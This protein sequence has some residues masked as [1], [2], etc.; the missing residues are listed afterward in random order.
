MT[1]RHVQSVIDVPRQE[2][3]PSVPLAVL[4]PVQIGKYFQITPTGLL[5]TGEPDFDTC[6]G[7][8]EML[9]TFEVGLQF[10]IG[11]YAR[12]VEGRF[13]EQASQILDATGW[14]EATLRVYTW[15]SGKVPAE[16]R[17]VDRGLSFKH[18]MAVAGL[19]PSQQ[20]K[21]LDHAL[22]NGDGEPWSVNRL[23]AAVK[24]GADVTPTA[25]LV[26]AT[27]TSERQQSKVMKLLELEGVA[28]KTMERRTAASSQ[29][30]KQRPKALRE[31]RT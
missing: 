25:W 13:G 27:C 9:R 26:L 16:N 20:R 14:A 29:T 21:W 18:H 3:H 6:A 12:Y 19:S 17:M 23:T 4:S 7:F 1:V 31:A 22:G 24:A 10:A 11:D 28:C 2:S 15:V 8:G 5:V 30:H